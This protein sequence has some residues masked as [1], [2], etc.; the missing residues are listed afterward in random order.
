M[1]RARGLKGEIYEERG[2]KERG[3]ESMVEWRQKR[4]DGR[5]RMSRG[6]RSR[7]DKRADKEGI[8]GEARGAWGGEGWW[9]GGKECKIVPSG[10]LAGVE[11]QQKKRK[12]E[13]KQRAKP[14]FTN[15]LPLVFPPPP[16][17]P[18][19]LLILPL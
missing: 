1:K 4:K 12:K 19:L 2:K 14:R 17:P 8:V 11:G 7:E 3:R 18:S 16:P 5:M 6:M 9:V 15:P 13:K 10:S